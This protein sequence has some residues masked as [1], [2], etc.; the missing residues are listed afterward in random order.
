MK[1]I[2]LIGGMSWE[3]SAEY[4]RI[5]NEEI[6]K[7]LGGLHSAKCLLYS[8][9]FKEIEHYQSIGA[10]DKAGEA[11]GQV[12]RSLEKAGADFIVICTNTMHKVL[13]YI[14]EMITIPI[15]HIADATAEQIIR[16]DI[17]SIGLLGT[18]YTMEQ[19]FYKSR[20]ASHDINVIVP[21]DDE[22]ELIN[23]II[24]QELCLGEIK[25][26]SKNIYKKIINNLVNRGAEGIIL[27]C[28]EIGLLVKAEDSKVPL[29][30]TTLIHAQKAVNKS[31]S[32]SS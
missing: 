8:V 31:L 1:T 13:G 24:Y 22:R 19:D 25:Q 27:G 21:D 20:I 23:N 15:L 9:D 2:G 29:F 16:Q 12:A 11:L 4:Y 17:R 30:D 7:K 28:T 14:Q 6:K 10:W 32:I 3:S 26:S 5:I 18:K